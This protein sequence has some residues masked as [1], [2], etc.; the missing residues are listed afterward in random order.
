VAVGLPKAEERSCRVS[1][2]SAEGRTDRP[3]GDGF[4][5]DMDQIPLSEEARR[6]VGP[7]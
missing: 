4:R 2:F 7:E 5:F 6:T 3:E 1:S